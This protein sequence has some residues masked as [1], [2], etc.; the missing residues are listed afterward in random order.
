MFSLPCNNFLQDHS[1]WY[2]VHCNLL[3]KILL[4]SLGGKFEESLQQ[5]IAAKWLCNCLS[6]GS[7]VLSGKV[8]R[9]YMVDVGVR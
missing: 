8:Y 7:F 4:P 3:T 5:Q 6:T 1:S 2:P 9:N